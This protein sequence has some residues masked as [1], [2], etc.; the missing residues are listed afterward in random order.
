MSEGFEREA[1]D[2]LARIET[3]LEQIVDRVGDLEPRVDG[4]EADNNQRK[5]RLTI[6]ASLSALVGAFLSAIFGKVV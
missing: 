4:L 3:K 5:G 6:I 1:I 2:R